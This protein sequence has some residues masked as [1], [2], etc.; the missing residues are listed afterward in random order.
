M[1]SASVTSSTEDVLSVMQGPS[2]SLESSSP[3]AL[4][5][6]TSSL[7]QFTA[8]PRNRRTASLSYHA[9]LHLAALSLPQSSLRSSHPPNVVPTTPSPPQLPT[10]A[11]LPPLSLPSSPRPHPRSHYRF[12]VTQP[13]SPT[14]HQSLLHKPSL[15][16]LPAPRYAADDLTRLSFSSTAATLSVPSSLLH[17]LSYPAASIDIPESPLPPP[18]PLPDEGNSPLPHSSDSLQRAVP[19]VRPPPVRRSPRAWYLMYLVSRPTSLLALTCALIFWHSCFLYA[20]LYLAYLVGYASAVFMAPLEGAEVAWGVLSLLVLAAFCG[21]S[22][23]EVTTAFARVRLRSLWVNQRKHRFSPLQRGLQR[24]RELCLV[25]TSVLTAAVLVAT[26]AVRGPELA[27]ASAESLLVLLLCLVEAAAGVGTAVL[28]LLLRRDFSW[29]EISIWTPFVPISATF[30]STARE[31]HTVEVNRRLIDALPVT[32]Y[33]GLPR[34]AGRDEA[35]PIVCAI[36]L[37]DLEDGD[38]TRVLKCQ[39]TY[40]KDCLD[41]WLERRVS[42]PLCIRKIDVSLSRGEKR[43]RDAARKSGERER[44]RAASGGGVVPVFGVEMERIG[45]GDVQP[46]TQIVIDAA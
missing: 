12:A 2:S 27:S 10:S 33:A 19:A 45:D 5:F 28:V 40:H 4:P 20:S 1:P 7:P 39:H 3:F 26:V 44:Q 24:L 22:A 32:P 37:V 15:P 17:G 13:G 23:V 35:E 42:C 14:W 29:A 30:N 9:A 34:P 36:C 6:P 31:R 43:R 8:Q 46:A 11:L 21:R 41:S 25:V 38:M 18:S 16:P